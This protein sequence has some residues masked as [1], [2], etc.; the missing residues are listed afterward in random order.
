MASVTR[1]ANCMLQKKHTEGTNHL[2]KGFPK[3]IHICPGTLK[4]EC[5]WPKAFQAQV[6]ACESYW[7]KTGPSGRRPDNLEWPELGALR[8]CRGKGLIGNDNESMF[9]G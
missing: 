9:W 4:K 8:L 5:N 1:Y 6:K 7:G 2:G 3:K